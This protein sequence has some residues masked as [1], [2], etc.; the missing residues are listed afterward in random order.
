MAEIDASLG[1]KGEEGK[2]ADSG[3]MA[4]E[5]AEVLVATERHIAVVLDQA[6]VE[7]VLTIAS[8]EHRQTMRQEVALVRGKGQTV[9]LA[10]VPLVRVNKTP[11][12]VEVVEGVL[13]KTVAMV[14]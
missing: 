9:R 10:V 2:D 7:Q 11:Q 5:V 14:V 13:A 4:E 6:L 12:M 8:Q 1:G 3:T